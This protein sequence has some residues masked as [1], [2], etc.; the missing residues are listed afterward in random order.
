VH[1]VI[2][3]LDDALRSDL[4]AA[5]VDRALA[6]FEA[7]MMTRCAVP[8]TD[9][10][11]RGRSTHHAGEGA[12]REPG[13]VIELGTRAAA[14]R[15]R[16]ALRGLTADVDI[17]ARQLG[18]RHHYEVYQVVV[19]ARDEPLITN[20]LRRAWES[21]TALLTGVGPV[22]HAPRQRAAAAAAWRSV[23]LV[24][25]PGRGAGCVRARLADA[26]AADLLGR[27]ALLLGVPVRTARRPGS[28]LVTIEG[29]DAMARL[30]GEVSAGLPETPSDALVPV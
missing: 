4:A 18:W 19:P 8:P 6:L 1:R 30:L 23:L 20:R 14:R 27:A 5:P 12:R 2:R 10:G 24:A 15:Y 16:V 13:V 21:G 29:P 9:Q 28:Y 11:G 22:S 3:R 7:A 17:R 25:G 26:T